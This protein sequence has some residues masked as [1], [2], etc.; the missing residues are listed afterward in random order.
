MNLQR[1]KNF[2]YVINKIKNRTYKF[3]DTGVNNSIFT[4]KIETEE[5]SQKP[6]TKISSER[7]SSN[8]L[9]FQEQEQEQEPQTQKDSYIKSIRCNPKVSNISNKSIETAE[10]YKNFFAHSSNSSSGLDVQEITIKNKEFSIIDIDCIDKFTGCIMVLLSDIFMI[11]DNK[12][13]EL[14]IKILK[15]KMGIELDEKDFYHKFNYHKKRMK[16]SKLTSQLMNNS[17]LDLIGQKYLMDY[18]NINVII[19]FKNTQKF[20]PYLQYNKNRNHNL[21]LMWNNNKYYSML[22]SNNY[23]T[24]EKI[25]EFI[26]NDIVTLSNSNK[27]TNKI[28]KEIIECYNPFGKKI[29]SISSYKLG[30]LQE[31]AKM[32][33]IDIMKIHNGKSKKKT[34]KELHEDISDILK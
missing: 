17:I 29:K 25:L 26:G 21:I 6:N 28:G 22:C 32:L 33:N 23:F 12:E 8:F 15:E 9:D 27:S 19:Y 30:E 7:M 5:I 10:N 13:K 34:K 20:K 14:Y 18:F 24:Y 31:K 11:L 4:Q 16:K 1:R 2:N 3:I